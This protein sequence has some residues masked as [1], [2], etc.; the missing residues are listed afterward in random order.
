MEKANNFIYYS[1]LVAIF[2]YCAYYLHSRSLFILLAV[3]IVFPV[4]SIAAAKYTAGRLSVRAVPSALWVS[5]GSRTHISFVFNNPTLLPV[6]T[7]RTSFKIENKY[8]KNTLVN[9]LDT[10]LPAKG[11][12]T[13]D[14]PL[15]PVYNGIISVTVTEVSVRDMLNI[16]SFKVKKHDGCCFYIKPDP[17]KSAAAISMSELYSE[18]SLLTAKNLNGTQID[19]TRGYIAGD[20]LRNIHWKLSTKYSDLLV[21]EYSDSSEETAI[22]LAELYTPCI[23]SIID[24][25]F[26]TGEALLS[27]GCPYTLGFVSA[28]SEQLTRLYITNEKALYDGITALYLAYDSSC[29]NAALCALRREYA[30]SGIIY[31]HGAAD[32]KAVTDII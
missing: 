30:G 28:G 20:K 26:G 8:L 1:L 9:C 2:G 32:G 13:A 31:I 10:S 22:L 17:D 5:K 19:G 27:M 6:I 3:F 7:C 25:V 11:R 24:R 29:D 12:H 18:D 23:D 4:I 16:F 21:K 14:I 15:T